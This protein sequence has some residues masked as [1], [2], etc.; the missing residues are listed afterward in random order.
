MRP[1]EQT[2]HQVTIGQAESAPTISATSVLILLGLWERLARKK[3]D[4]ENGP[5]VLSWFWW[6]A[7]L[8]N[9]LLVSV[10]SVERVAMQKQWL[11][12][13]SG[14]LSPFSNL[15]FQIDLNQVSLHVVELISV[16][17]DSY[18]SIITCLQCGFSW[19]FFCWRRNYVMSFLNK[20]WASDR[21]CRL[22]SR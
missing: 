12:L 10:F 7:N 6:S 16:S 5:K 3:G 11:C 2:Y 15:T 8:C 20:Y 14:V 22:V 1:L 4:G 19:P 13:A 9:Q 21:V 18:G 17:F